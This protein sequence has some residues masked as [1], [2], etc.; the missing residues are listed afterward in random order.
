[1]TLPP[2]KKLIRNIYNIFS[3]D[4]NSF[5][6][7]QI[8]LEPGEEYIYIYGKAWQSSGNVERYVMDVCLQVFCHMIGTWLT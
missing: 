8:N 3:Y 2:P 1:M 5:Q 6:H 4:E 7:T